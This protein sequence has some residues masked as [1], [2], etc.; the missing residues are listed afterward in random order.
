MAL[1]KKLEKLLDK[2]EENC[3]SIGLLMM[4][5]V[6]IINFMGRFFFKIG[7]GWTEEVA[8][9][10][11][12]IV[13]YL[14]ISYVTK[15]G[16]HINMTVI[17]ERL[18]AKAQRLWQIAICFLTAAFFLYLFYLSIVYCIVGVMPTGRVTTNLRIPN[19][20]IVFIMAIGMLLTSLRFVQLMFFN[21]RDKDSV[22]FTIEH[23]G[24]ITE[25]EGLS[26][27]PDEEVPQT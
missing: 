2:F 19:Y 27:D 22:W 1:I 13:T 7:V 5:V 18:P 12:V 8:K 9:I 14:G 21:I 4:S 10:C 24:S 6:L 17:T 26:T 3:L 11:M 25:E 15:L 16:R 23:P 20:I